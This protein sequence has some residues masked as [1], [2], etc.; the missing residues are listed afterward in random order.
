MNEVK[1]ITEAAVD[2]RMSAP[3]AVAALERLGHENAIAI[4]TIFIALG[5]DDIVTTGTD[6][7]ARFSNTGKTIQEVRRQMEVVP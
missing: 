3:A 6:G 4:E 7:V 2:G 5:G 1:K